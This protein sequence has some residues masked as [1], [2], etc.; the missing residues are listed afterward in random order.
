MAFE[1]FK[2]VGNIALNGKATVEKGLNEIDK[3]SEKVGKK[4]QEI[5]TSVSTTGKGMTKWVTGPLV[6]VGTALFGITKKTADAGDAIQKMALRTGLSTEALS[7]YKHAAELSGTSLE[8]LEKGVKRMQSTI[9]DAEQG[10]ATASDALDALGVSS[11]ELE[12][13]SPEQQFE[14]LSSA[15]ADVDDASRKA[16]LAQEIF[17]RAGTEMLPMLAQ[18]SEGIAE[19]RQEA[20]DLGIVFDQEAADQAANFNDDLL[21]LQKGFAGI[22]Q[23]LG[24][25]LIP[26]FLDQLFPA[27]KNNVIP[28]VSSLIELIGNAAAWFGNLSPPLQKIILGAVGLAGAL[29]PVLFFLGPI[30]AG[31]GA[32]LSPI[33]LVVVA[34]TAA[35]AIWA[36]FGDEIKEFLKDAWEGFKLAISN[37]VKWLPEK[38]SSIKDSFLDKFKQIKEFLSKFSLYNIGKNIIQGLIDGI[39]KLLG[40][41]VEMIKD[42]ASNITKGIKGILGIKSPSKVFCGIGKN[43]AK[44]LMQGLAATEGKLQMQV[45]TMVKGMIPQ[46]DAAV[47]AGGQIAR[48]NNITIN[49]HISDKATADYATNKLGQVIRGRGVGGG[50]L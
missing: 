28:A 42:M 10:L 6:A 8:S 20:R 47:T 27:I 45:D 34:I 41:P 12:G 14:I 15:L 29:G 36:L 17:G 38:L 19:M 18:G 31:I 5:G 25:K 3:T 24:M 9:Y 1:V 23:E 43:M 22:F 40:K 13:K 50:F 49:Q 35:V 37:F 46:Q 30:I 16:A 2:L 21:R 44:G 48:T 4:F 32:L 7:E 26:I 33:G 11:E 39:K